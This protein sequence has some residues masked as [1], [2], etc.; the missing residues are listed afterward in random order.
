MRAVAKVDLEKTFICGA[1]GAR[2]KVVDRSSAL[3]RGEKKKKD[4]R[5]WY[6]IKRLPFASERIKG[7]KK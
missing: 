5:K 3:Y 1:E 6:Y 7:K 4:E 2:F